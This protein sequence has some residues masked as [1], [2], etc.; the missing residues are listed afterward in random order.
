M[1]PRSFR[2]LPRTSVLNK[3][4]INTH[5]K[6][7]QHAAFQDIYTSHWWMEGTQ[8]NLS[9]NFTLKNAPGASQDGRSHISL[10]FSFSFPFISFHF[11]P[12]PFI[13]QLLSFCLPGPGCVPGHRLGFLL[14]RSFRGASAENAP[15]GQFFLEIEILSSGPS[16]TTQNCFRELLPRSFRELPRTVVLDRFSF[17]SARTFRGASASFRQPVFLQSLNDCKQ[18]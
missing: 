4:L 15:T 6:Y 9:Q 17:A 5:K 1:L 3:S 8:R 18:N 2:E 7:K 12:F 14:P 16:Y 10:W 13:F 11:F